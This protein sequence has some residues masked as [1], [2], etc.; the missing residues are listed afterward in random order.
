MKDLTE[1]ILVGVHAPDEIGGT[2]EG[3]KGQARA[4]DLGDELPES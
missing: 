4:D 1:S 2:D 3:K